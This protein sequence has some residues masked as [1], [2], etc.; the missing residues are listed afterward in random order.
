MEFAD[1]IPT[2]SFQHVPV[3]SGSPVSWKWDLE[4]PSDTGSDRSR[5]TAW[6][7]GVLLSRGGRRLMVSL[8][9]KRA[10]V[11]A[12]SPD[13][14]LPPV[15]TTPRGRWPAVE[16]RP[17]V[18]PACV[19]QPLL[20]GVWARSLQ[21]FSSSASCSS[22]MLLEA[23]LR[24]RMITAKGRVFNRPDSGSCCFSKGLYPRAFHPV[25][26][27]RTSYTITSQ[28]SARSGGGGW[29]SHPFF[30]LTGP[31]SSSVLSGVHFAGKISLSTLQS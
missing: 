27:M 29:T 18:T 9:G 20:L 15:R 23:I 31:H 1:R 13:P 14:V 30:V 2:R 24:S 21:G 6:G 8:C 7:L 25:Q 4:T 5:A 3:F 22:V 16:C 17:N 19:Q 11:S 10:A 12:Q 26:P 28:V